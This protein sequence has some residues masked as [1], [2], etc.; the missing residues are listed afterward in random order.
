MRRKLL[1][2][3]GLVKHLGHLAAGAMALGVW[4]VG[5]GGAAP[6]PKPKDPYGKRVAQCID[7]P[8]TLNDAVHSA[9]LRVPAGL[10]VLG[11]TKQERAQAAQDYGP[12]SQGLF[13]GEEAVRRA[14][15]AGFRMDVSPVTNVLYAEFVQACG[16]IPPDTEEITPDRWSALRKRFGLQFDFPQIQGFL[17]NTDGPDSERANH[18]MVLVT[19]RQAGLYCAWRGGRL[20]SADEWER[21]ARGPTGNV[22]P[23]GSRY[24]PYRAHTQGRN[25]TN[26]AEIGSLPQGNT[27]EGFT[28]MGGNVYE[29]T[30]TPAP[31]KSG[32]FVVKGNGWTGRGGFGRGAAR[33]FRPPDYADVDLGFRCAADL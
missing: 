20:P 24:D 21:A 16:V 30:Q 8:R 18:P 14:R 1:A 31:G 28:D 10:A 17:W 23:W 19:Q 26:T 11:S 5:C 15:V 13:E 29:W 25:A 12:G 4:A 2:S 6:K 22:Y 27:P 7:A 9:M 33:L 3:R 32:E